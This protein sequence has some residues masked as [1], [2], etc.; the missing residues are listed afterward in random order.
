MLQLVRA[1]V[2]AP[3]RSLQVYKVREAASRIIAGFLTVHFCQE[4]DKIIF[5]IVYKQF[6]SASHVQY[7][8]LTDISTTCTIF[9]TTIVYWLP[10]VDSHYR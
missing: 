1:A 5:S 10:I 6:I 3:Q 2:A 9:T 8:L 4:G 7:Y